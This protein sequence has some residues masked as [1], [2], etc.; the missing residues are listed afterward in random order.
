MPE[1]PPPNTPDLDAAIEAWPRRFAGPVSIINMMVDRRPNARRLTPLLGD[2]FRAVRR[3]IDAMRPLWS[4]VALGIGLL[5]GCASVG[6]LG[7]WWE[8]PTV[9]FATPAAWR[10]DKDTQ[11][12]GRSGMEACT[13]CTSIARGP[14][15]VTINGTTHTVE[16]KGTVVICATQAVVE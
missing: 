6:D 11:A 7:K 16:P 1:T 15:V 2:A 3:A 4:A 13:R 10:C 8:K 9:A 5:S 12:P 14:Q